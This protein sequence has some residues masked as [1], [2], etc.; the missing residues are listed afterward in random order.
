MPPFDASV[1]EVTLPLRF[2][3]TTPGCSGLAAYG[4]LFSLFLSGFAAGFLVVFV[5]GLGVVGVGF[6]VGFAAGFGV[7]DADA[8]FGAAG[9]AGEGFGAAGAGFGGV[10]FGA[11]EAGGFGAEVDGFAEGFALELG[12]VVGA[13][14]AVHT[15]ALPPRKIMPSAVAARKL[16]LRMCTILDPA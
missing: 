1:M 8:G 7:V 10:V 4:S 2:N 12:G 5:A 11:L 6:A 13:A 14:N 9:F 3:F 15:T 16:R